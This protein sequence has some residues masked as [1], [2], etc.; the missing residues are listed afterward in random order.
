MTGDLRSL[1][2]DPDDD[3]AE[4]RKLHGAYAVCYKHAAKFIKLTATGALASCTIQIA[5]ILTAVKVGVSNPPAAIITL[6]VVCGVGAATKLLLDWAMTY[7]NASTTYLETFW[8]RSRGLRSERELR[9]HRK[10]AREFKNCRALHFK[11]GDMFHVTRTTFVV[12]T[13]DIVI[14]NVV[15]LI[16]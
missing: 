5:G 10:L 9:R 13:S 11:I 15:T 4:T 8:E 3:A 2:F 1:K 7:T 6:V 16:A 12:V 14:Q